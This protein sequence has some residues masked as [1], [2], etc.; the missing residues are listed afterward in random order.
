MHT[1]EMWWKSL[2]EDKDVEVKYSYERHGLAGHHSNHSKHDVMA[3]FVDINSRP[4]GRHA[5][6]YNA[7]FFISKFSC[8]APPRP[9]ENYDHK[10]KASVVSEF[11]RA[12]M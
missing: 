12:Q 3:D 4:N 2:G 7:Q 11:N 6:S 9:G 5:G 10:V 1:L 8:I